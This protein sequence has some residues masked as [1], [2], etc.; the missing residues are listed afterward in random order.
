MEVYLK[1]IAGTGIL[2]IVG[3]VYLIFRLRGIK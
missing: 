3:V 2:M 1:L